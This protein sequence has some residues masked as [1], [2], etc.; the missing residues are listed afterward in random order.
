MHTRQARRS[1]RSR[2]S[3]TKLPLAER[4][5]HQGDVDPDVELVRRLVE[6]ADLAE[7]EPLVESRASP[8]V[9]GDLR[10]PQ[11]VAEPGRLIDQPAEQGLAHSPTLEQWIDVDEVLDGGAHAPADPG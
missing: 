2:L 3:P 1:S 11:P 4:A 5:L 6:D 7:A 10:H 8:V 9:G